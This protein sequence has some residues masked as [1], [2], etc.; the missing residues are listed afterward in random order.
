MQRATGL[1]PSL[2]S[3]KG[4]R[5]DAYPNA[6]QT[7]RL[8]LSHCRNMSQITGKPNGDQELLMTPSLRNEGTKLVML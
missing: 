4:G 1:W 8:N 5:D 6:I 3:H 7:G 2:G